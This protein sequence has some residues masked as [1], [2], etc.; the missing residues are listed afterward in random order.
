MKQKLFYLSMLAAAVFTGCTSSDEDAVPGG[1]QNSNLGYVAVNIV[2]VKDT[3]A[4]FQNG[5]EDESIAK[6]GLFFIYDEGTKQGTTQ[7]VAFAGSTEQTEGSNIERIYDA[8]LVIDGKESQ[9]QNMSMLCV[10]NAPAELD[11]ITDYDTFEKEIGEYG[12]CAAG[13]F[14][15]SN[16]VYRSSN[17]TKILG[18][19]LLNHV[20]ESA[21]AAYAN[22]I[23]IYV[24]RIV[25]KVQ[26]NTKAGGMTNDKGATPAVNGVEK[27]LT[28][29]LIG[30]EVAN[31]AEK[32]YL[33]K[34]IANFRNDMSQWNWND[35]PNRRT[36]WET[37]PA[38]GS[39]DNQLTFGNKS[40]NEIKDEAKGG[41]VFDGNS[42]KKPLLEYVQPNTSGSQKTA[43]LVTAQ[44]MDGDQPANL[45]YI[46]GGYTTKEGAMNVIAKHVATA[47][48]LDYWKKVAV[49]GG[50][51][52]YEQLSAD[53][54]IWKNN[55]DFQDAHEAEVDG[56]YRYEV[57]AQLKPN[58]DGSYMTLYTE[59]G[60]EIEDGA[61]KLN[62]YFKSEEAKTY[63]ARV[64]YDGMCYYFEYIDQTPV[65]NE[66]PVTVGQKFDAH[67]YDGV[68]RNHIYDLSLDD[69]SGIGTPIF[70]PDDVII[71][72]IPNEEKSYYLAAR[73]NVLAWKIVSQGV[74]FD[75][76]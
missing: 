68:I 40:Y 34:D 39:G 28:I 50:G 27:K 4:E 44:L 10:L 14:I 59:A 22:P 35:E 54:F 64:F 31:I 73:I 36:Y 19:A 60:V 53:D 62:D 2:Q 24:E 58:T 11:G 48:T 9:P 7:R 76:K 21:P 42:L 18:D 56:L 38:I 30:A 12:A 8:V 23:D 51:T 74:S 17:G 15:M 55:Q 57:V 61:K 69:I 67:T 29:K 41:I 52:E 66:R 32:A 25:A 1:E 5:T 49:T 71:P 65:A 16:S 72:E 26:A 75:G 63:R 33:F 3:R 43:V 46:R 45:A 6:E 47:S 37:V 13:Q 70:D 20:F